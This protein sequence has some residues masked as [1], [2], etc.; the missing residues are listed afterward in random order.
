ME[1]VYYC[2]GHSYNTISLGALKSYV[3]FQKFTSEPLENC[4][5]VGPQVCSLRSPY[6]TRIN[7]HYFQIEVRKYNPTRKIY[8]VVPTICSLSKYNLSQPTYESFGHF[9]IS[10]LIQIPKKG[11]MKVLPMNSSDLENP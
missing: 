2:P 5:F 10:R 11:I 3:D 9:S 7:L 1:T 8:I 4:D 6:R